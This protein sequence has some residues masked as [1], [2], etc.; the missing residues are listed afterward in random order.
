MTSSSVQQSDKLLPIVFY[1]VVELHSFYC[2]HL[3]HNSSPGN[4]AKGHSTQCIRGWSEPPT[5]QLPARG[6]LYEEEVG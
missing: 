3:R 2:Q 5:D 1:T 6:K 4:Y